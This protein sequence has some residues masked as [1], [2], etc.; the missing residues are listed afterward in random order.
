MLLGGAA[1]AWPLPMCAQEA[2]KF[3]PLAYLVLAGGQDVVIVAG[4]FAA[5]TSAHGGRPESTRIGRDRR[6]GSK[7]LPMRGARLG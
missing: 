3:Y 2:G 7:V 6:F 5:F 4:V 1:V